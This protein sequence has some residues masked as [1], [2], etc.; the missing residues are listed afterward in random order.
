M[1]VTACFGRR[2]QSNSIVWQTMKSASNI[3]DI[4]T[5]LRWLHGPSGPWLGVFV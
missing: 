4:S 2:D 5:L 1:A 3:G